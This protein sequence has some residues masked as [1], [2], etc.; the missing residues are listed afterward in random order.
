[1]FTVIY[2]YIRTTISSVFISQSPEAGKNRLCLTLETS[3]QWQMAATASFP[4]RAPHVLLLDVP[5]L[6]FFSLQ[7]GECRWDI[8]I[9]YLGK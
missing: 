1:M 4:D 6:V 9:S 3:N 2:I 7:T 8:A 5:N